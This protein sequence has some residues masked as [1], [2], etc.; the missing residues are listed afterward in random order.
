[1]YTEKRPWG[2]FTVLDESKKYKVKRIEVEPGQRLSYQSH[3]KR[4]ELWMIVAG[5]A[6]V[7]ID[8]KETERSYGEYVRIDA[9]QKH[10]IENQ[11]RDKVV[12]IE[13]QTGSYF[14]EEDI[15]RYLDDYKRI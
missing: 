11:S 7:T 15:I 3:E 5:V 9:K 8:D 10:R 12:F 13:I 14:G 4:D 2:S 1:M 6:V